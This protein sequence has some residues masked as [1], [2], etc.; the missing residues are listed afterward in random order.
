LVKKEYHGLPGADRVQHLRRIYQE[1]N[2][3][4][5]PHV[6]Y[7]AHS[8]IEEDATRGGVVYLGPKGIA[9][10]PSNVKELMEALICV[11]EALV[12]YIT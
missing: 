7:L 4:G 12:V 3:K 1:L 8:S 11:L 10:K 6:D 2:K 5:V 9:N